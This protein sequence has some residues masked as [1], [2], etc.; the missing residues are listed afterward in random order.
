[1]APHPLNVLNMGLVS[2]AL[3]LVGPL[4]CA[5]TPL[6]QPKVVRGDAQLR[7]DTG[8]VVA[9][10][11]SFNART[12]NGQSPGPTV[13]ISPDT[14]F[15][16]TLQNALG[17]GAQNETAL[18]IHGLH[19]DPLTE[20]H[21]DGSPRTVA[22]GSSYQYVYDIRPDHPAGTHWYHPHAYESAPL[23]QADGMAGAVIVED[24]DAPPALA[25]MKDVVLLLQH[26]VLLDMPAF[27]K[28][29]F[30][31]AAQSTIAAGTE[32]GGLIAIE[33]AS[34]LNRAPEGAGASWLVN[35]QQRPTSTLRPGEWQRWRLINAAPARNVQLALPGCEMRLLATDGIYLIGGA[36]RPVETLS[37]TS[38]SRRD[39]AVRCAKAGDYHLTTVGGPELQTLA[40][41]AGEVLVTLSAAGEPMEME[42][43]T[44]LPP[45]PAYLPDLRGDGVVAAR[46]FTLD[47]QSAFGFELA[48][49]DLPWLLLAVALL[50]A[51]LGWWWQCFDGAY[52]TGGGGR[53]GEDAQLIDGALPLSTGE[54]KAAD[55]RPRCPCCSCLGCVTFCPLVLLVVLTLINCGM[56]F[57][58]AFVNGRLAPTMHP[59]RLGEVEE[60]TVVG[61]KVGPPSHPMHLHVHHFQI[62]RHD[63]ANRYGFD[64][65]TGDYLDVAISPE[66]EF[67]GGD[68][69]IRFVP[70][71]FTGLVAA[72]C[73][74]FTHVAPGMIIHMP[75]SGEAE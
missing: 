42:E 20:K 48:L 35:G 32:D 41:D 62:V 65:N 69:T 4:L 16:I 68:Y 25:A 15:A 34:T 67:G 58:G 74:L 19:V 33:T 63:V 9:D 47:M 21:A 29:S 66:P 43:P 24:V 56:N 5:A 17:P 1:M 6:L 3:L 26:Y 55:A 2:V 46:P 53:G 45:L 30:F 59:M 13:V 52:K 22:P 27:P 40:A 7:V 36:A 14:K 37:F 54:H 64:A 39:V 18:H 49:N 31:L 8:R 73:H 23:Q 28:D 71:H 72:H 11:F 57:S 44:A 38:G 10:E 12:Y 50:A 61:S 70:T 75:V 60:W 51:Y